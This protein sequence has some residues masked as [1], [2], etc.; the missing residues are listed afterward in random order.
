MI[1]VIDFFWKRMDEKDGRE[2]FKNF[3]SSIME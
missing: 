1:V 2:Q 3:I